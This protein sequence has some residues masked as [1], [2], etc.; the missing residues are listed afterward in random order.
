MLFMIRNIFQSSGQHSS[1]YDTGSQAPVF[2]AGAW[3]IISISLSL[4]PA[5]AVQKRPRVTMAV[6]VISFGRIGRHKYESPTES[7]V[8][9]ARVFDTDTV[10]DSARCKRYLLASRMNKV[11]ARPSGARGIRCGATVRRHSCISSL[12]G[13][14]TDDLSLH[15]TFLWTGCESKIDFW[16][17]IKGTHA[18]KLGISVPTYAV[19]LTINLKTVHNSNC[20]FHV[21]NKSRRVNIDIKWTARY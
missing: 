11:F 5:A 21:T 14:K 6:A 17:T 18:T 1:E 7:G 4:S 20:L 8:Y 10:D 9:Y 12:H 19:K 13:A 3:H 15:D 2:A 16:S